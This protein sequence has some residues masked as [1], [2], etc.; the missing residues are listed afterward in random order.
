M[1]TSEWFVV[2]G[3]GYA[4]EAAQTVISCAQCGWVMGSGQPLTLNSLNQLA[5]AHV[6]ARRKENP[7]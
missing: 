6:C 7:R 5:A 4:G 1:N 3:V 2:E